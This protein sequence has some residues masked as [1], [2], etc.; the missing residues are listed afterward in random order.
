MVSH[1]FLFCIQYKILYRAIADMQWRVKCFIAIVCD[2]WEPWML[3]E[4]RNLFDHGFAMVFRQDQSAKRCRY[5]TLPKAGTPSPDRLSAIEF[6]QQQL[7]R[8]CWVLIRGRQNK[9]CEYWIDVLALYV[10][11]SK[12]FVQST[13]EDINPYTGIVYAR[14]S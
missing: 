5:R 6:Q 3:S 11:R 12:L 2:S 8:Q 1:R 7:F 10:T 13:I 9:C 14:L 4:R